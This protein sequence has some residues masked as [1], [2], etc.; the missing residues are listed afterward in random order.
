MN[1]I[2]HDDELTGTDAEEAARLEREQERRERAERRAEIA[3]IWSEYRRERERM[4]LS[5]RKD[6]P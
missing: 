2:R 6:F 3:A 4:G 1:T 5:R